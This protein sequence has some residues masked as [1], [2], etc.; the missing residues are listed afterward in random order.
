[1]NAT[2]HHVGCAVAHLD[3][4]V[5]MYARALDVQRMTR[6][7]DISSQ[8]VRVRFVE[9]SNGLYLELISPVDSRARLA[10]FMRAG[11]YHMAFLVDDLGRARSHLRAQGLFDLPLFES[12]AF[13]GR[14]CQFF[15][16]PQQH[17]IELVE[18]SSADFA[19]FFNAHLS[20]EHRPLMQNALPLLPSS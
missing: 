13:N 14:P 8:H 3:D 10:S 5:N 9:L 1:M 16:T 7:F 18:M 11:F 17:L 15:Q 20:E 2:P 12:E 6:A 4:A 19:G